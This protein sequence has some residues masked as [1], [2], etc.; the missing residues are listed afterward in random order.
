MRREI[1][2]EL[3]TVRAML[4]IY[5]R[6]LHGGE[7]LCADCAELL[8]YAAARLE[9]CPHDPKPSCKN[10]PTHCYSPARRERM[11]EVMK[12]LNHSV[13]YFKKYKLTVNEVMNTLH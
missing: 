8:A 13:R 7:K 1:E 2:A 11:K 10:C 5:C 4:G 9:K 3:N 6:D 12:L